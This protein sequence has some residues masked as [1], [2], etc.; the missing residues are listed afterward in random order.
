[1]RHPAQGAVGGW[2]MLGLVFQ[3][4]PLHEFSL[5]DTLGLALWYLGSWRSAPPAKSQGLISSFMWVYIFFSA[6]QIRLSALVFCM[7]F[8]V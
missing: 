8:C 1:M 6:G 4:F 3:G 2:V 5:F 7:H